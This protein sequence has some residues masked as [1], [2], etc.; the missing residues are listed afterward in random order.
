MP[1]ECF[2]AFFTLKTMRSLCLFYLN[3]IHVS[4]RRAFHITKLLHK[5][6]TIKPIL[7]FSALNA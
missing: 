4:A 2:I 7:K 6:E 3:H 5:K 1:H